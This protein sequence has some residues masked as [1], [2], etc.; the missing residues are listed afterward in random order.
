MILK[1][2]RLLSALGETLKSVVKDLDIKS[3]DS[4]RVNFANFNNNL[5]SYVPADLSSRSR[6]DSRELEEL[7]QAIDQVR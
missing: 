4:R 5:H 6:D 1:R 7:N 2:K 3:S